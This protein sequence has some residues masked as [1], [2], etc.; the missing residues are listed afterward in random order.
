MLFR[1]MFGL[2]LDSL[3]DICLLGRCSRFAITLLCGIVRKGSLRP[4]VWLP[5]SLLAGSFA[6]P[7]QASLRER[8]D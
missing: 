6:P 4:W 3:W 5:L 2:L 1:S 8:L 7:V